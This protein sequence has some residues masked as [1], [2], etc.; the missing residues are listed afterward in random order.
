M[1]TFKRTNEVTSLYDKVAVKTL[2]K[3][4][5]KLL[6]SLVEIEPQRFCTICVFGLQVTLKQKTYTTDGC[7]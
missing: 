4:R 2:Q 7:V 5:I 6:A 1:R 3:P